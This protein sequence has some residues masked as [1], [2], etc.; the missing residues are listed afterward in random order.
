MQYFRNLDF[1]L[2]PLANGEATFLARL[3]STHTGIA[4]VISAEEIDVL[5]KWL[6][7]MKAKLETQEG[8]KKT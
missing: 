1:E 6:I 2:S 4:A 3:S 5:A 7:S 8:G